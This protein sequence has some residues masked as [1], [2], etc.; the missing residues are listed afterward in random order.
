[1]VRPVMESVVG[2]DI[3]V[4]GFKYLDGVGRCDF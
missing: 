1:M 2:E 3:I 4:V